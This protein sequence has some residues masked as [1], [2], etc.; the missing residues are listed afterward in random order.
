M[1]ARFLLP[2]P[3]DPPRRPL[4]R[5][6]QT[7]LIFVP[8]LSFTHPLPPLPALS[9]LIMVQGLAFLSKKSW[10]T[11]NFNNQEKVWL[12]EERKK[13]EALKTKE[14]QKQIQQELE[15]QELD[16]IAGRKT[17]DRGIDWM[18]E[19]GPTSEVAQHD[20]EK[21]SE[22][23]LLGKEFVPSGAPKGDLDLDQEQEGLNKVVSSA[24][25]PAAVS[26]TSL[27]AH[28]ETEPTVKER[29]EAFRVRYEDPMFLVAQQTLEKERKLERKKQL[30]ERVTGAV[31]V[32]LTESERPPA[33]DL[34]RDRNELNDRRRKKK[35]KKVKRRR[36]SPS[37]SADST[38][39][40]ER[41]ARKTRRGR[42]R[43]SD[44]RRSSS[45]PRRK[46]HP[47]ESR[48]SHELP[49]HKPAAR[50]PRS[51][52]PQLDRRRDYS[53]YDDIDDQKRRR[54]RT[55]GSRSRSSSSSRSEV[56]RDRENYR[57]KSS[58]SYRPSSK[59]SPPGSRR[60]DDDKRYHYRERSRSPERRGR[61]YD[62][63]R[64]HAGER[65]A[66]YESGN[67]D[68]RKPPPPSSSHIPVPPS[69]RDGAAAET[70]KR[71]GLQGESA[72]RL[73]RPTQ[74]GPDRE[75]LQRKR[76]GTLERKRLQETAAQR[77]RRT[78]DERARAVQ[79][80]ELN[81]RQRAEQRSRLK[82]EPQ[83]L[84][85]EPAPG[86]SA[87]SAPFILDVQKRT[88]GLEGISMQERLRQN[89][90]TQQRSH[91]SFL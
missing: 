13:A 29:N 42:S 87:S 21:R 16:A 59:S 55:D 23:Y 53:R 8:P 90:H 47:E 11:K 26:N 33:K 15:Q 78:P 50:A 14:L 6:S 39:G 36:R 54:V 85:E 24:A 9:C 5:H 7:L 77:T 58:T 22:E 45:P 63:S 81:A 28:G 32:N 72:A 62:R 70:D 64:E 27:Q 82:E 76:D 30:L 10:H 88:Y 75:L 1:L 57:R 41:A 40:S 51:P 20:A 89:R 46:L 38:S 86:N 74:L 31:A 66:P 12:A 17:R 71:Y 44:H 80:M 43:S 25:A 79:E 52:S 19:H 67:V 4:I 68:K 60:D 37:H 3:H 35:H 65:R 84:L 49:E 69:D 91:E 83:S 18:Y 56:N 73:A 48:R 2:L 34:K 61:H